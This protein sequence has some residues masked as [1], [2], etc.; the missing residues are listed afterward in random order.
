MATKKVPGC[1]MKVYVRNCRNPILTP[2]LF[3]KLEKAQIF[4][5]TFSPVILF[6]DLQRN[7]HF[8]MK[9]YLHVTQHVHHVVMPRAVKQTGKKLVTILFLG[10]LGQ[11]YRVISV[12]A[13]I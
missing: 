7:K 9:G 6:S 12:T 11:G 1:G 5:L 8:L 3:L 4:Y 10:N 13:F 2:V